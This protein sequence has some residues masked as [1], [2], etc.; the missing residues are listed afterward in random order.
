MAE[1]R[2]ER[3]YERLLAR[4]D[5][6][7]ASVREGFPHYGDQLTGEWTR[8]PSGDWTGGFWNGMCWLAAHSTEKARYRGWALRWAEALLP[9]AMS[10]TVFRGFLFYYGALLGD[11]LLGDARAREI[12]LAGARAWAAS[13]NEKAGV[14]GLG[15]EAEEASDVGAGEASIDTVQ[16]AALLV[17]A[18]ANGGDSAWRDMAI[19]HARRHVELCVRD[20]GSICQSASF[21]ST[22]GAMT[23]RYTHKGIRPDST[24]ARAQAWGIVGYAVMYQWTKEIE[25]LDAAQFAAQ[26]WLGHV[27]GD[28]VAYWDFDDPD[29][30]DTARDTS[31]TAIVAAA[32]LKLAALTGEEHKQRQYRVAAEETAAALVD[33]YLDPRGV[34]SHGCYNRRIGLATQNELIWG[35]YYLFEALHVLT[36]RLEPARF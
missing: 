2:W 10:D 29:I 11:V 8:S 27:A 6:T 4:V 36:G 24:W 13:F 19:S 7:G 1:A 28:R 5:A 35:S 18:A 20:D 15:A 22:T 16:G 14:F 25:F 17:W 34:L 9:R 30:P 12:A 33:R 21:D 3:G 32:L 26:W 31:A 23:R